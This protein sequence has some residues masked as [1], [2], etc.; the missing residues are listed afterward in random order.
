MISFNLR[1]P[2]DHVFE[3]WFKDSGTFEKQVKAK[4]LQ[5]PSCGD[6]KIEKALM[7]PNIAARGDPGPPP[8]KLHNALVNFRKMVEDNCDYVG[9][10]FPEEARKIHYGEA[11]HRNIYGEATMEEALDLSEEGVEFGRVPWVPRADS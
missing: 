9:P 2:K 11:E 10:E 7:S 8:E 6:V 1:C 3:A 5:C 4:A